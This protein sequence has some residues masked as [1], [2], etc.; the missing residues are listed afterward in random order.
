MTVFIA[1][2]GTFSWVTFLGSFSILSMRLFYSFGLWR[3][4]KLDFVSLTAAE[5]RV[6]WERPNEAICGG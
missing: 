2:L 6:G 1:F 4:G 5:Y 3:I